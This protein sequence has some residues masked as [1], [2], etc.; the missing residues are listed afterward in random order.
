MVF[1]DAGRLVA[2]GATLA[3]SVRCF[4]PVGETDMFHEL[5]T[6]YY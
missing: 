4:A 5:L 1:H 2:E 6:N 3:A